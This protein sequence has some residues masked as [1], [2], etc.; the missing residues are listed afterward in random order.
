MVIAVSLSAAGTLWIFRSMLSA[1]SAAARLSEVNEALVIADEALKTRTGQLVEAQRLGK[2]GDWSQSLSGDDLWWS[3]ETYD[4][5]GYDPKAFTPTGKHYYTLFAG[6]GSRRLRELQAEV[7]RNHDL[8]RADF[9]ILRGDGSFGDFELTCKV[10]LDVYGAASGLHGTI[11]DISE[12]KAAETKLERLAYCDQLTGLANRAQFQRYL[13]GIVKRCAT[14]ENSSALLLL[15]LDKFKEVNDL[16]GHTA[17][18]ELLVKV[19]ALVQDALLPGSFIARLGGDE[20]AVLMPEHTGGPEVEHCAAKVFAALS[21]PIALER[22]VV[23]VGTSIGIARLPQDGATP[24]EVLRHADLALYR[25]KERGRNRFAFFEHSMRDELQFKTGLVRDLR[26]ALTDEVGLDLHFQPQ[27]DLRSGHISGFEALIRWS[28]PVHG[29]VPPDKFIP[30]AENAGLIAEV[31]NWV[32]RRAI[33]T[34]KRW[35]ASGEPMREV[36]VNMSATQVWHRDF[37]KNVVAI[38]AEFDFPAEFL[39]LELTESIFADQSEGRMREALLALKQLGIKL[40]LDDF[41]TGY[42]SLGYLTKLPFDKLKIDRV[43]I[44][45]V[46]KS[47]RAKELLNGIIALGHGL[48]ME[49]IAEGAE[50]AEEVQVLNA[51]RCHAVQGYYFARPC[52]ADA[53]IEHTQV[54]RLQ[55]KVLDLHGREPAGQTVVAMHTAAASA[56]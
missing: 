13:D 15:D 17:G 27:V 21:Q 43:F 55:A 22:G 23:N 29:N 16:L 4:L 11:Q 28:H 31:G 35:A 20:F 19:A 3:S 47:D 53:A 34:A 41:G 33:V 38:L 24:G 8:G 6:D 40:A 5:L 18:D 44:N 32:M 45:N 49:V 51:F 14:G 52:Q 36:A 2:L 7:L 30:I 54:L 26:Q 48:G 39:C 56:A 42:S 1:R 25:A 46:D 50:T 9:R 37:V 12:R 10:R